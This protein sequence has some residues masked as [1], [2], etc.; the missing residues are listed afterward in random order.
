MKT[1]PD[2]QVLSVFIKDI[3]DFDVSPFLAA[4]PKLE[5]RVLCYFR[6]FFLILFQPLL[7]SIVYNYHF[8]SLILNDYF[9]HREALTAVCHVLQFF[10]VLV[11]P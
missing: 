5:I 1:R 9:L 6:V 4:V 7:H 2:Q 11:L 3:K 10:H 8:T